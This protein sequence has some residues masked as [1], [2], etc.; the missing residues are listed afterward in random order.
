MRSGARGACSTPH[1]FADPTPDEANYYPLE[2]RLD[3]IQRISLRCGVCEKGDFLYSKSLA[4]T[5]SLWE[6]ALSCCL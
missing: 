2:Q 5:L 3:L 1:L 4:S 6:R